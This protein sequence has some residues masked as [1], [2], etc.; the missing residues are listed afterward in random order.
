[1][2]LKLIS[3][4][5]KKPEDFRQARKKMALPAGGE[6]TEKWSE[7]WSE[8]NDRQ[9]K[10]LRLIQKNPLISRRELADKLKINQ[11]AIQKHIQKLK[12]QKLLRR[13]GAA[14]GGHWELK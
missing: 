8:L 5:C 9:K 14:K 6:V 2:R 7:K 4:T 10:I 1:M 3:I 13:A 12:H 11:S